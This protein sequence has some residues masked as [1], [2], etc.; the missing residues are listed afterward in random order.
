MQ[1]YLVSLLMHMNYFRLFFFTHQLS[2]HLRSRQGGWRAA[3]FSLCLPFA[4]CF[5]PFPSDPCSH[6]PSSHPSIYYPQPSSCTYLKSLSPLPLLSACFP[7]PLDSV[8]FHFMFN[9]FLPPVSDIFC[10]LI[11]V[12]VCELESANSLSA[13]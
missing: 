5:L 1:T 12:A 8:T 2:L 3:P 13:E 7:L 10:S 11:C 6:F 9:C 4:Y